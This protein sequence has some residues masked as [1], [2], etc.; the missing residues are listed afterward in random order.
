MRTYLSVFALVVLAG[1]VG[2]TGSSKPKTV[3]DYLHDLDTAKAVLAH[4][5]TDLAKYQND[6]D[7]IN[8]SEAVARSMA[9]DMLKCWPKKPASTATTDH[10]CLDGKGYKKEN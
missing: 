7:A 6:P 5:N 1:L 10:A 9:P 2:C 4:A 3:A 8:A